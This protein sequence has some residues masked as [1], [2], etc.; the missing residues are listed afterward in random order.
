L[1][2][3]LEAG[4]NGLNAD[5]FTFFHF[6]SR[7]KAEILVLPMQNSIGSLTGIPE[8]R[9]TP[10]P[11][12]FSLLRFPDKPQIVLAI[13][14]QGGKSQLA[15]EPKPPLS[16]TMTSFVEQYSALV[17]GAAPGATPGAKTSGCKVEY[18]TTSCGSS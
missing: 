2:D 17:I 9:F 11:L 4:F 14:L 8:L 10:T 3:F 12:T 16:N 1:A 5:Q 15:S 7:L 18:K 6:H 13:L